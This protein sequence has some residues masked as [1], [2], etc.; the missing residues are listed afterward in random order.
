MGS[1]HTD[2]CIVVTEEKYFDFQHH[3]LVLQEGTQRADANRTSWPR[4]WWTSP[5]PEDPQ[6]A[7]QLSFV[8]VSS[9]HRKNRDIGL[10]HNQSAVGSPSYWMMLRG[11]VRSQRHLWHEEGKRLNP[12]C[13]CTWIQRFLPSQAS[14]T[15]SGYWRQCSGSTLEDMREGLVP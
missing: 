15:T 1:F 12:S 4:S 13:G 10:R 9:E 6:D 11:L 2:Q 7:H 5:A 8:V 14:V 3:K